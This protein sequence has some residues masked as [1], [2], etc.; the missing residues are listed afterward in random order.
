M[1]CDETW[2]KVCK[3][4]H[5][6]KCYIGVLVNKAQKRAVFFYE[7]GFRGREVLTDFLGDAELKSI[8]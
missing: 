4:D 3:Y 7:N 2:C 6:K 5:Y 8:I 1:N